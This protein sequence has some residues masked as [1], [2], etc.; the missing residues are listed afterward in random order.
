[1]RASPA[2]SHPAWMATVEVPMPMPPCTTTIPRSSA[3]SLIR[4]S[5]AS[6]PTR[7][8]IRSGNGMGARTGRGAGSRRRRTRYV[9]TPATTGTTRTRRISSQ[10]GS[11]PMSCLISS[12]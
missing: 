2:S 6:L 7:P 12:S 4:R 5:S 3:P 11:P 1:M 9:S 8:S 10:V